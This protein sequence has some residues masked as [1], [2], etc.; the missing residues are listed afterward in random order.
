MTTSAAIQGRPTQGRPTQGR[1]VQVARF[2]GLALVGS[3]LLAASA[4]VSIPAWPVPATLQSLAVLLLG[5]FGGSR[6][7]VAA[8]AAYLLEGALGLPV[9]PQPR[10]SW[11]Y[12]ASTEP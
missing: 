9:W 3:A 7:R 1:P 4:Q 2:L 10:T 8:V 12:R 6:L 11:A 5:A